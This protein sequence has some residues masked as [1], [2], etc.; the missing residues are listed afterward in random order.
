MIWLA[1]LV[2][3]VAYLLGSI[4]FAVIFT[5]LF[6]KTDIRELGSGNAGATNVMRVGGFLPGALTFIFDALKGFVA[7]YLAKVIFSKI[8]E[9]PE[10][11]VSNYFKSATSLAR[12]RAIVK[13]THKIYLCPKCKKRLKVPKGKGKI[14]IS[15]PCSHKFYKRT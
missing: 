8:F 4:S 3:V 14:E 10:D 12:E 7:C 15:C 2:V 1:V 9:I 11:K 5:K 13:K 6:I